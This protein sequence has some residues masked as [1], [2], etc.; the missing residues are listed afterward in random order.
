MN[1]TLFTMVLAISGCFTDV[2]PDFSNM[3]EA[4]SDSDESSS[5]GTD[6]AS[7]DLP[8]MESTGEGDDTGSTEDTGSTGDTGNTDV[9]PPC[10]DDVAEETEECDGIDLLGTT[11][12]DGEFYGGGQVGCSMD[13]LFDFSGCEEMV[14][15]QDFS[16]G[17]LPPEIELL[18][19]PT[20]SPFLVKGS[21]LYNYEGQW[22]GTCFHGD[23]DY[24]MQTGDIGDG[25]TSGF[26][27]N[28]NFVAPGE[29]RFYAWHWTEKFDELVF[30]VETPAE[31]NGGLVLAP[32]EWV[33]PV[34]TA[35]VHS[36]TWAYQKD[37]SISE[38]F[39]TVWIDSITVTNAEPL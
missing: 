8:A 3:A 35:G 36:L 24:C 29:V 10:G 1:R 19:E 28:M 18:G 34:D 16:T 39:D 2:N 30:Y 17:A 11:C 21:D 6:A 12:E 26:R 15:I 7:I 4:G 32:V 38:G 20:T 27:I 37:G 22:N 5:D 31:Q 14:Y 25:Q 13:C 9:T 23:D 33:I